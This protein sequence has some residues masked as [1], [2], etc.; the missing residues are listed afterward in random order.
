M[1]LV[2]VALGGHELSAQT[3]AF[4]RTVL[5]KADLSTPGRE[6]VQVLVEIPRRVSLSLRPFP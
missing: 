2:L 5:Q 3:G 4:K 1:V 6:V